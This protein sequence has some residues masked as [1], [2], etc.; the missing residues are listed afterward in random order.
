M[1]RIS[2]EYKKWI[3]IIGK[4]CY[5]SNKLVDEINKRII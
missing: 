1:L 3:Y 5:K 4:Q 2:Y